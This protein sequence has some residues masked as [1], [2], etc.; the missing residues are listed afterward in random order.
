MST[1]VKIFL[2]YKW[3][4][5]WPLELYWPFRTFGH[6]M[7]NAIGVHKRVLHD[8]KIGRKNLKKTT[9]YFFIQIRLFSDYH[10]EKRW[11]YQMLN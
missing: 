7:C 2:Y 4:V 1:I 5:F 8:F 6:F 3:C 11:S 10:L 9:W